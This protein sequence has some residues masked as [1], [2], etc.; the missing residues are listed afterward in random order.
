MKPIIQAA[1]QSV[2]KMTYTEAVLYCQFCNYNGYMDWRMPT[3]DEWCDL[4]SGGSQIIRPID[5]AVVAPWMCGDYARDGQSLYH[6]WPVRN[7]N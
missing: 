1:P 4:M 6:A 5:L 3:M 2:N 7:F